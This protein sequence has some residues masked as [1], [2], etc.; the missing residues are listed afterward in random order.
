MIARVIKIANTFNVSKNNIDASQLNIYRQHEYNRGTQ[1]Q[2]FTTFRVTRNVE[3]KLTDVDKY[4]QFLQELVEAGVNEIG[5]T[6]FS[7]SKADEVQDKLKKIGHQRCK[8]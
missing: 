8:V 1:Q 2:E 5:Y 7:Y 6:Q 4:P 3:I